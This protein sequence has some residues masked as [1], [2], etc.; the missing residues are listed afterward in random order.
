[1][2]CAVVIKSYISSGWALSSW[3]VVKNSLKSSCKGSLV[4]RKAVQ[5]IVNAQ[6]FKVI[7]HTLRVDYLTQRCSLSKHSRSVL[8]CCHRS[9]LSVQVSLIKRSL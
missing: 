2:R 1:M 4:Y 8:N 6:L 5:F 7:E 9:R 3:S